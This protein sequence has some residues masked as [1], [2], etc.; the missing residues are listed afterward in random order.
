MNTKETFIS[1]SSPRTGVLQNGGS[2]FSTDKYTRKKNLNKRERIL[3]KVCKRV[4]NA[5]TLI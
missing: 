4:L 3:R 1:L 2:D 5:P